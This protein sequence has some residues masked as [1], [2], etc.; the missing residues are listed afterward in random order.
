MPQF[1]RS[2]KPRVRVE[3]IDSDYFVLHTPDGGRIGGGRGQ[4]ER[5]ARKQGWIPEVDA[6][7]PK[8][9]GTFVDMSRPGASLF[10]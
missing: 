7:A 9:R 2:D 8:P 10:D 3:R 1:T 6:P 4:C 5:Y